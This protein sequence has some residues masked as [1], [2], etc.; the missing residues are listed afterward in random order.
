MTKLIL[1]NKDARFTSRLKMRC[2][3]FGGPRLAMSIAFHPQVDGWTEQINR[4][5]EDMLQ[6]YANLVQYDGDEFLPMV[7]LVYNGS[8]QKSVQ[9]TP[10]VLNKG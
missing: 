1:N 6:D 3:V 10:F 5:F 9:N 2:M 7:E 8:W 4:I